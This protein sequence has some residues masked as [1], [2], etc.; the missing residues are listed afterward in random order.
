M[1]HFDPFFDHFWP[2]F[3]SLFGQNTDCVSCRILYVFALFW[4]HI[5]GSLFGRKVTQKVTPKC[6]KPKI[7]RAR[8]DS[9][10][11]I[12]WSLLWSSESLLGFAPN[13]KMFWDQKWPIFDQKRGQKWGTYPPNGSVPRGPLFG[14]KER[15]VLTTFKEGFGCK[16]GQKGGP[17]MGQK[18]VILGVPMSQNHDFWGY[19]GKCENP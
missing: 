16:M 8:G 13:P 11:N 18:C 1:G 12:T 3:E 5:L 6:Q 14:L 15:S 2:I 19:P 10:T 17:K 4:G 9:L 7:S